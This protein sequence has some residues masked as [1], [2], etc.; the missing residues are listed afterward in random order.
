MSF[1]KAFIATSACLALSACGGTTT[2]GDM[3]QG[4]NLTGT[5]TSNGLLQG[6]ILPS[7]AD[8]P[9]LPVAGQ[10]V[11]N[12]FIALNENGMNP[13]PPTVGKPEFEGQFGALVTDFDSGT[14]L[15]TVTGAIGFTGDFEFGSSSIMGTV[16]DLSATLA[17]RGV[18]DTSGELI[19]NLARREDDFDGLIQGNITVDGEPVMIDTRVDGTFVNPQYRNAIGSFAGQARY[20][21]G[22]E[23]QVNGVFVAD[24]R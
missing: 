19:V 4:I 10:E 22:G 20:D 12:D 18:V 17:D 5:Q 7:N 21:D 11:L 1:Q 9:S 6:V 8:I 13:T 14:V 24:Q 16:D 15:A 2:D 3:V 23:D